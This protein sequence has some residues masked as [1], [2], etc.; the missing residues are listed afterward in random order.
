VL[1]GT[2]IRRHRVLKPAPLDDLYYTV[3]DFNIGNEISMY[4]RVF[5]IVDCDEF[6]KNFQRKLGFQE[7][8]RLQIPGDPYLE[9]RKAVS[10][11]SALAFHLSS[12]PRST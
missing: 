8:T 5:K 7:R 3:E 10:G 1:T 12:V 4:G 6:T 11:M 9:H 2:L